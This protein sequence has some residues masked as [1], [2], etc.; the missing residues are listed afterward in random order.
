MEIVQP[1]ANAKTEHRQRQQS[2]F[3][4][5]T[6]IG[7]DLMFATGGQQ[8]EAEDLLSLQHSGHLDASL[9]E[10]TD[11]FYDLEDFNDIVSSHYAEQHGKR[12]EQRQAILDEIEQADDLPPEL[13]W[14]VERCTTPRGTITGEALILNEPTDEATRI[15]RYAK[16]RLAQ[17]LLV[18]RDLGRRRLLAMALGVS[19]VDGA[20]ESLEQYKGKLFSSYQSEITK[21]S[22]ET[23]RQAEVELAADARG[24]FDYVFPAVREKHL[25]E[26]RKTANEPIILPLAESYHAY[27]LQT[28]EVFIDKR[29]RRLLVGNRA[30]QSVL[31]RG[32]K[33]K[34]ILNVGE[35]L[36]GTT[37]ELKLGEL[38]PYQYSD[39]E[40]QRFLDYGQWLIQ[41]I[42]PYQKELNA[43]TIAKSSKLGLGPGVDAIISPRA[44][45]S[46]TQYYRELAL[47][48]RPRGKFAH[49][50]S[51]EWA[52]WAQRV[53]ADNDGKLTREIIVARS[54]E[55]TEEPTWKMVLNGVGNMTNLLALIGREPYHRK[56]SLE[57]CLEGGIRFF[58]EEGRLPQKKDFHA[59][60]ANLPRLAPIY[61]YCGGIRNF[62]LLIEET[63]RQRVEQLAA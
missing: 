61:K 52:Q 56:Q 28:P 15:E 50:Q 60:A 8:I 34:N 40:K 45:G 49:W 46:L 35:L 42:A 38:N 55:D 25:E 16:Y 43:R 21:A 9:G 18:D 5:S 12:T 33:P 13:F 26:V 63:L 11:V 14:T 27:K 2:V 44:F 48:R 4:E 20:P 41:L 53:A 32:I 30:L 10:I 62:G 23:I 29:Y 7:V 47:S 1:V 37:V 19:I 59:G 51:E 22:W 6:S 17:Q 3:L 57:E 31:E 54:Q 39:W 36:V 24:W 58:L